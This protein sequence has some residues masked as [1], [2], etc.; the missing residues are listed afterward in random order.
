ME[1]SKDTSIQNLHEKLLADITE[2][3]FYKATK[4]DLDIDIV[5]ECVAFVQY[6]FDENK[7]DY[8]ECM[9]CK[10]WKTIT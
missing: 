5:N 10:D 1:K 4:E 3:I 7:E 9:I 2:A 8:E 6:I